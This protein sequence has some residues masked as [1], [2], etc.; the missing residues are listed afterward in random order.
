M[1]IISPININGD[2]HVPMKEQIFSVVFSILL[3]LSA[4]IIFSPTQFL[5]VA[6]AEV[7]GPVLGEDSHENLTGDWKINASDTRYYG[8]RTI[9]LTGNLTVYGNLTLQNVTLRFN[10]TY[11]GQHG[12]YVK[13]GGSLVIRDNDGDRNTTGDGCNI[14]AVNAS[15]A[16]VFQVKNGSSFRMNNSELHY[17]GYEFGEHGETA[18]LWI[19]ANNT[20]IEGNNITNSVN[21]VVL[22]QV[23]NCS[24]KWSLLSECKGK[25]GVSWTQ[26]LPGEVGSGVYLL[27]VE[28]CTMMENCVKNV[29]GGYGG[30]SFGGRLSGGAGGVGAGIYL[31]ASKNNNITSNNVDSV[32]GAPGGRAGQ[33]GP[34]GEGGIGAGIY[35]RA[36]A[37]NNIKFTNISNV[38][39]GKGGN[40]KHAGPDGADNV[41][42]GIY[43]NEDSLDNQIDPL[44]T[45]NGDNIL[46]YYGINTPTTIEN[47]NLS[48]KS[49]PTNY[50]E[51]VLIRCSNFTVRNNTMANFIGVSGA[52]G[53]SIWVTGGAGGFAG[54]IYLESSNSNALTSNIIDSITGGEGG[55]AA[56][57]GSGGAGGSA[58]GISLINSKANNI[59]LNIVRNVDGGGTNKFPSDLAVFKSPCR[60]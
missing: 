39:G 59:S 48:N 49:N 23:N 43:I 57:S 7:G 34:G 29:E 28:N 5:P 11:D 38:M 17:C 31:Q 44:N 58:G 10:S 30:W 20:V 45:L 4:C 15:N 51:I 56:W 50:G 8:N 16:F 25:N 32:I 21:G 26:G 18:G 2:I 42:Y 35:L 12:I 40:G 3:L 54:G 9:N 19:N 36:S 41:G 55:T 27:E 46:Y 33:N 37:N 24:V 60:W 6:K 14:T 53:E 52:T 1:I 47:Y 13:S 22:Y